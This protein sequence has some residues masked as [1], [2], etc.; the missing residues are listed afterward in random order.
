MSPKHLSERR[1]EDLALDLLQI[2]SWNT[3]KPPKGQVISQNEYKALPEFKELFKGASKTGGGDAYPEFLC[4]SE[5]SQ[6][7]LL[8]IECKAD[9]RD[10]K[11]A[12][13]EACDVYGE[14]CHKAGHSVIAIGIAGQEQTSH[15][16]GVRRRVN[17]KWEDVVYGSRPISWIPRPADAEW[18]LA[19]PTLVELAPVVPEAGVL[20]ARAE[21]I[22]RV[23]REASV[24]DELRPA[25]VGA[26]MLALWQSKGQI[27]KD[28]DWVLGD[29]NI[30]CEVAFRNAGK[31]ELAKSLHIDEANEKLAVNAWVIISILEK[32]NVVTA[33]FSHDYLGQ[34]Y[35]AFF[36]YTGGN[37]IG[38]YFT[39]RHITRF[40]ADLCEV[41]VDDIVIDPACGTGGFLIAALQRAKE[42]SG[43]SYKDAV[44]MVKSNLIGYEDEPATAALCVANM[45]LRGD[46]KSGVNRDDVFKV[47]KYPKDFCDVSLMN[48]PFP[49]KKTDVPPDRFIERA[50]EA[51][52]TRGKLAVIVP[53]SFIVKKGAN[54]DWR[55][56]ILKK[57]SLV[58]VVQLPDELFQPY[59][60]ATTSVVLLEKGVPHGKDRKSTFVR[61]KHDGYVLKK[62]VRVEDTVHESQLPSAVDAVINR[63]D[64]PGFSGTAVVSGTDEWS[65]GAYIPAATPSKEELLDS[66][67]ELLR[68]LVSFYVRYAREV[69][70]QRNA[71]K[72]VALPEVE[73]RDIVSETRLANAAALPDEVGTIG[74]HFDILYG[75]KELHSRDGI[76]PG[77]TLVISPTEE[78]NGCYGWLDFPQVLTAPFATVA[79]TG[80]IGE[81]FVQFESCAVNDDCLVLLPKDGETHVR[82]RLL[83][84]AGTIGLSVGGSTT[85]GS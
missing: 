12:M 65:A 22:N 34:L 56:K 37:T 53:T 60:S 75:Q 76:P 36:R 26:F 52:K 19:S 59:A 2:R 85:A 84:A 32:L 15:K 23:L 43:L 48:P 27:R 72:A 67:D 69:A 45:I 35:E 31:P 54:G 3:S 66:L 1:T 81:A 77:D 25:Y 63:K 64:E 14:A 82:A 41:T 24:R 28:P 44:N 39:P 9:E 71:I 62:R 8:V 6:R 4:I 47:R 58:G 61:I 5:H 79:Q 46:G 49:H 80:S 30:A 78:Y 70:R 83:I 51:L 10:F 20:A 68:R 73:Y 50:L 21:D 38:Q 42:A 13:T 55:E 18:L 17:G 74:G 29:V 57:N 7:P 16:V 11:R 40:M 33:E